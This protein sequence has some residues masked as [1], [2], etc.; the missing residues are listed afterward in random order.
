ML[1]LLKTMK[2]GPWKELAA[3][4]PLQFPTSTGVCPLEVT[5][6]AWKRGTWFDISLGG[7][8]IRGTR[9]EIRAFANDLIRRLDSSNEF[10]AVES[11]KH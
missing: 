3:I 5:P 2:R 7:Y 10:D 11:E 6:G 9:D 4:N 8:R 1:K